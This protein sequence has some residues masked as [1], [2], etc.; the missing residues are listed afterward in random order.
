MSACE[1]AAQ[2]ERI[3]AKLREPGDEHASVFAIVNGM[4][5]VGDDLHNLANKVYD[6]MLELC[7]RNWN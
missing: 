4:Q 3:A 1:V 6:S 5:A 7:D 2:L